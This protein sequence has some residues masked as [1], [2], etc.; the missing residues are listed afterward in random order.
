M[1]QT[2]REKINDMGTNS[3]CTRQITKIKENN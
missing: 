1:S 3:H 2:Q